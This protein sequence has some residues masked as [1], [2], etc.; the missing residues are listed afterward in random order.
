[1]KWN[2]I[3]MSFEKLKSILEWRARTQ[4]GGNFLVFTKV[5][6]LV[7]FDA[8]GVILLKQVWISNS[9][10]EICIVAHL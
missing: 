8:Y 2:I 1:M 5:M 3:Y 7:C 4:V 10:D 6:L 9:D